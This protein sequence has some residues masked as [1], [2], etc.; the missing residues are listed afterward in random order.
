MKRIRDV[1][2][3][4]C[5][6][7]PSFGISPEI[8]RALT[9]LAL[10]LNH[11]LEEEQLLAIAFALKDVDQ[12]YLRLACVEL[13]G[14]SKFWPKPLELRTTAE[15]LR[16]TAEEHAAANRVQPLPD[17]TSRFFCT[18]CEDEPS[19]LRQLWCHGV[20]DAKDTSSQPISAA[21]QPVYPCSRKSPH[22]PHSYVERCRCWQTNPIVQQKKARKAERQ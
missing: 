6:V 8:R 12:Q 7:R 20:G 16:R 4:S 21:N 18:E 14:R 19:G 3:P 11:G 13:A 10:A 9:G 1:S 5:V 15:R 22:P 2:V 17:K